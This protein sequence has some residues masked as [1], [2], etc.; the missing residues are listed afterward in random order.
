MR[1]YLKM[2]KRIPCRVYPTHWWYIIPLVTLTFLAAVAV[3][4]FLPIPEAPAE[5]HQKM[6]AALSGNT[7]I[8]FL[9]LCILTPVMEEWLCRGVILRYLLDIQKPWAAIMWSAVVFAALHGNLWQAIP[10]LLL[11]L[12]LG[13]LYYRLRS[14]WLCIFLHAMNNAFTLLLF[15]LLGERSFSLSLGELA[16]GGTASYAALFGAMLILIGG[17][18]LIQKVIP[19][20]HNIDG[21]SDLSL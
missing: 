3:I 16:G 17:I 12:L 5:F 7:G 2:P 10:A 8:R 19:L 6:A 1:K 9:V 21:E 4:D 14:L 15:I 20:K 11:G 13:W 18:Y